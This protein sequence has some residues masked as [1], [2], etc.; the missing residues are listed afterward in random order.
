[1]FFCRKNPLLHILLFIFGV[2]LLKRE[3]WTEEEKAQ[4][5]TKRRAFRQKMREAFDVWDKPV[6]ST[7]DTNENPS[8]EN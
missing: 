2:K 6:K 1:M 8:T 7:H 4:Y 3:R 5:H